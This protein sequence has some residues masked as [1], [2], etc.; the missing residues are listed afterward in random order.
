MISI[1]VSTDQSLTIEKAAGLLF[2]LAVWRWITLHVRNAAG[3]MLLILGLLIIGSG[4]IGIGFLSVDWFDKVPAL[5]SVVNL[6]PQ[7]II[8][9]TAI[10][11]G[12]GVQ[13]NQ[14]AGI[15]LWLFP[16]TVALSISQYIVQNRIYGI[17]TAI[18]AF[19]FLNILIL[20]QS[21]G[22]WLG[23]M[24]AVCAMIW[25]SAFIVPV[26]SWYAK[27][28]LL[29]PIIITSALLII[30]FSIGPSALYNV[31]IDPPEQT[32]VGDLGTIS[33]RQEVWRWALIAIHDFP[34]TGTGLG[35]FRAVAHRI[36][37]IGI[38]LN[39]DI[40]HA[41][42]VFLQVA[43]DLGLLGLIFYLGTIYIYFWMGWR[44][45][46]NGTNISVKLI[47]IGL[48]ASQ[49]GFHFYGLVD[50][51]ALGAKPSFLFWIQIGLMGTIWRT[52]L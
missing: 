12:Q 50:A 19:V 46:Q 52:E 5:T 33:F 11:S 24:V 7:Q 39:Y 10:G 44:I 51:I 47:V 4:F 27:F 22:G 14:L 28:R 38:P 16:F 26:T 23:G 40:A 29:W 15:L 2:G 8:S 43:L 34:I 31:W 6:F 49:F 18:I 30:I 9:F 35:S 20:S 32:A 25:L 17:G 36:Y 41:H 45:I 37:P 1:W 3:Q 13:P 48:M 42:N 21:R